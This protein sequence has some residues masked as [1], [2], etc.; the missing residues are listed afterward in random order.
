[1]PTLAE[2]QTEAASLFADAPEGEPLD[3]LAEALVYL[4]VRVSVT[5]LDT[6]GI[7]T[8]IATAKAAGATTAQLLEVIGLVSALGV[9]S[10]MVSAPMVLD[11]AGAAIDPLTPEQAELWARH[12][13]DDP[14]WREFEREVPGFLD[15][16]LRTAPTLFEGFFAY[17]AIPWTT[18]HVPALVKELVAIACDATRTHRFG[19]G[20][21]LHIRNARKLGAGRIAIQR[22]LEIGAAAPDHSG[23]A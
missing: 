9:H 16:L 12:V 11:A 13:G 5:C 15:A 7:A 22:T 23:I 3:A 6:D 17:C 2:M 14:Y 1:M 19:P 8:A 18:R 10:L 20:L 21:R 4:G